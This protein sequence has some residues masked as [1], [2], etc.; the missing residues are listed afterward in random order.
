MRP[1]FLSSFE[2][3]LVKIHRIPS[4][5]VPFFMKWVQLYLAFLSQKPAYPSSS[6]D[7]L[8]SLEGKLQPWQITQAHQAIQLYSLHLRQFRN[9]ENSTTSK[10]SSTWSH[11][12]QRTQDT[13]R[14]QGKSL[15]TEK[16]YL[17][18]V[19]KFRTWVKSAEPGSMSQKHLKEFLTQMVLEGNVSVSTQKQAFHALLFF[20]RAALDKNIE[21]LDDFLKS[22]KR[23]RLPVVLTL[24]EIDSLFQ[25]MKPLFRIMAKL[26]YGGGLRLSECFK[27]RIKDIDLEQKVVTVRS[28]KGDKDRQ[29]LLSGNIIEELKDHISSV[30][31]L[32]EQD[33]F[34]G[35]PGVELPKALERK[36]PRAGEE[37]AWFW[38]FP[39]HKESIDPRTRV[40][41]RHHLFPS[42]LQKDFKRALSE[43]RIPKPASVHTLRHSFATHLIEA[44]YDIR[45]VQ[46]L[47]GHHD[48]ATTM[49]YTHVAKKNKLGVISPADKL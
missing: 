39:S 43:A 41:R 13:L 24:E 12:L 25:K 19:H 6:S 44:G 35:R 20:F 8:Q 48:L 37:W 30:K 2:S 31:E 26:I 4:H 29:T 9:N 23:I 14:I 18:W 28:G 34:Q 49:I 40:V 11:A 16:S 47:L 45:T 21:G 3:A 36:Y 10:A 32:Y 15:S 42:T 17:Y 7:F 38:L 1:E 46:E 5:R 33:R 22:R 27:L